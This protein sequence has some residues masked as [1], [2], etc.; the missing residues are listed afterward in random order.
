VPTPL[1]VQ[2]SGLRG[3]GAGANR[4]ISVLAKANLIGREKNMKYDGYRLT[5]GGLDY[6]ALHAHTKSGAI[7]HMGSNRTATGKESDIYLVTTPSVSVSDTASVTSNTAPQRDQAVFKIHR[8]GRTSFRTIKTNRAYHGNRQHCTW[9]R[10]SQL[11]AQKEFSAMRAL[12]AAGFPVPRPVAWNRHTVVMSLV[13]GLPLTK[14]PLDAFG[15]QGS[16]EAEDRISAL[17]GKLMDL[18]LRLAES[19][20]IHGDFNEFN[21]LVENVPDP[22]D[23]EDDEYEDDEF[24][25]N[26]ST[27]PNPA[28]TLNS[29]LPPMIPHLIDFP[30]ITSLQHPQAK[31]YFDRDV[32]CIKRFFRTKYHFEAESDGP[33][34]AE[35]Q[36]RLD[37]AEKARRDGK[38]P[39]RLDI[40][41]EAA[42]FSKKLAKELTAYYEA[43]PRDGEGGDE[44]EGDEDEYE[45]DGDSNSQVTEDIVEQTMPRDMEP[46]ETHEITQDEEEPFDLMA[47]IRDA[48]GGYD[49]PE[50]HIQRE[51]LAPKLAALEL[52]AGSERGQQPRKTKKTAGWSI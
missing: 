31:F 43:A 44:H 39:P 12:H 8:L 29:T 20:V 26:K 28:V 51:S 33:T 2:L 21:L 10:L 19:A 7:M 27:K 22:E 4:S 5:Y 34:F 49:Q 15:K 37:K 36:A 9:Q 38:G 1:I 48:S 30:Q 3:G 47:S 50:Q 41:M 14:V 11:S 32:E 24:S 46:P 45:G 16:K 52:A 35:A 25:L 13:P 42:G 23:E 40:E 18:A 17:Y 6:L